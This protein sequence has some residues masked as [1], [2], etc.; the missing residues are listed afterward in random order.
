MTGKYFWTRLSRNLGFDSIAVN[1]LTYVS[2]SY[3]THAIYAVVFVSRDG[4]R[5]PIS[6]ILKSD[7]LDDHGV[8]L[9]VVERY[10]RQFENEDEMFEEAF[11]QLLEFIKIGMSSDDSIHDGSEDLVYEN[12]GMRKTFAR[13][14]TCPEDILIQT[15]LDYRV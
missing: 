12:C 6:T 4:R 13:N 10:P 11:K 5:H 15:D 14:V 9:L 2:L 3:D 8:P 7:V 1:P